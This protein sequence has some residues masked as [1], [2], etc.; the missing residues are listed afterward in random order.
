[1]KSLPRKLS[2]YLQLVLQNVHQPHDQV[3]VPSSRS[4]RYMHSNTHPWSKQSEPDQQ[5]GAKGHNQQTYYLFGH[6]CLKSQGRR[7][8]GKVVSLFILVLGFGFRYTYRLS[9]G[10]TTV[11]FC[12]LYIIKGGTASK[13]GIRRE[14]LCMRTAPP[15]FFKLDHRA[16][17]LAVIEWG[18]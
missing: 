3:T 14:Q 7:S 17:T 15:Q 10:A 8:G 16:V 6:G 1:M 9:L 2:S 13:D 4:Y 5:N 11:S 12:T 18:L